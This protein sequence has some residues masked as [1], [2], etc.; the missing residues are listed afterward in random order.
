MSGAMVSLSSEVSISSSVV[1]SECLSMTIPCSFIC[2]RTSRIASETSTSLSLTLFPAEILES[3]SATLFACIARAFWTLIVARTVISLPSS[4]EIMKACL[5]IPLSAASWFILSF[6]SSETRKPTV[7]SLHR[8]SLSRLL[9][10]II[11]APRVHQRIEDVSH[12]PLLVR[13]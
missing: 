12:V 5:V 10:L 6:S 11:L 2:V 1:P 8:P 3:S 9:T 7:V 13:E 4:R